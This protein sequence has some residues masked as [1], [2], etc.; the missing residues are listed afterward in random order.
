[1]PAWKDR[2]ESDDGSVVLY[3]GDAL[4][5]L[6]TLEGIDA[7]VTDPPYVGM[8]G[9]YSYSD[10]GGV[11]NRTTESVSLGD[12]WGAGFEWTKFAKELAPLGAVVFC[13]HHALPETALAFS[14]WRRAVLFTWHKRNAPCQGKNVPRFTEEYAWGFARVPGLAW[15]EIKSTL[16]DVPKLATGCMVS[17]ERVVDEDNR[18]LHPAQKPISVMLRVM[19]QIRQGM[20]V[21]DPYMGSGTTGVACIRTGRRFIGIE[22]EPQNSDSPDYFGIAVQRCKDE[23]ARF[24]LWE[25]PTP[26][27][28]QLNLLELQEAV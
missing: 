12:P 17:R 24:P 1:M 10:K 15:D 27:P 22:R 25:K 13:S 9:G 16:I 8:A 3:H 14:D 21:C 28:K 5:I 23:L 19:V 4:Q 18:A 11:A 20:T 7:I 26:S 2:W 6:P